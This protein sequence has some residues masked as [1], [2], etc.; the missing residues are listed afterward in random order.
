V[1]KSEASIAD[2]LL[3]A[4]GALLADLRKLEEAVR[5]SEGENPKELLARLGATRTHITEH[6]RFE[7]QNGYL[8]AVRQREPRLERIIQQLAEEHRQ[9]E[10]SLDTLV[11]EAQVAATLGESLRQ[12]IQAWVERV[13]RHEARENDLVQDAFNLDIG[14]ED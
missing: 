2:V 5:P 7:E 11:G 4:H 1:G 3:R 9:L 6:F 10:Q 8:D 14:A 13:R 12:E